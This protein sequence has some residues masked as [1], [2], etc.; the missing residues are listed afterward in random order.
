MKGIENTI[1]VLLTICLLAVVPMSRCIGEKEEAAQKQ[2][3]LVLGI[4]GLNDLSFNDNSYRG[5][6]DAERDFGV[7]VRYVEPMSI[8]DFETHLASFAQSREC[9]LIVCVGFDQINALNTVAPQF[10]DQPFCIIDAIVEHENIASCI[11]NDWEEAFLCGVVAGKMTKTDK[12]GIVGGVDNIIIRRF[13]AG[14]TQGALW[15]NS[16]M[17][18]KDVLVRF[19]GSWDDPTTGKMLAEVLYQSGADIIYGAA[20]KS[21]LGVFEAAEGNPNWWTMG[22]DVDQSLTCPEH[23]DVI[24]ASGLKRVDLAVYNEIKNVVEGTFEGGVVK[25]Y[26]MGPD[27]IGVGT[28]IALGKTDISDYLIASHSEVDIPEEVIKAV[29]EAINGIRDGSIIIERP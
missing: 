15:A 4:G 3:G 21:H 23:A 24:I 12:V 14:F 17:T 19:V 1:V 25:F 5:A 27:S 13:V 20:G 2:I 9:A 26:G 11:F 10:Q 7:K 28:G 22:T 18:E 16:K 29:E 6:K 8:A